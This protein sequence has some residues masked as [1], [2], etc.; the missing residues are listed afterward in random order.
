MF[1]ATGNTIGGPTAAARNVISGHNIGISL[2]SAPSTTVQGNFIGTDA[3]G[4]ARLGNTNIGIT[5]QSSHN[6]VIGGTATAAGNLI[7][8]NGTGIQ[9]TPGAGTAI[10]IQGNLIGTDLNGTADLGNTGDGVS[11]ND[12]AFAANVTIGGTDPGARNVISG[13]D[14]DGMS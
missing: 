5:V 4:T 6:T 2:N 9:I 10:Q 1:N 13:N 8:D 11:I 14:G 7:S 3:A 12:S